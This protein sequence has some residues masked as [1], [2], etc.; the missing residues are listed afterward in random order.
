MKYIII[1]LFAFCSSLTSAQP[2]DKK[3]YNITE[4]G[5]LTAIGKHEG[6]NQ[7]VRN[8]NN[9]YRLRTQFGKFITPEWSAGLGIGLDGYDSYNTMPLFADVHYY[10]ADKP[11]FSFLDLG[12][13]FKRNRV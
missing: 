13:Y 4:I 3:Y 7:K 5:Y 1:T 6:F 2:K 10:L 12:Y 11:W 9:A 8:T